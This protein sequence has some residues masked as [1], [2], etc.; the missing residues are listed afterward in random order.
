MATDWVRGCVF[1]AAD[2][3]KLEHT[4][5]NHAQLEQTYQ[6]HTAELVA[7]IGTNQIWRRLA[8]LHQARQGDQTSFDL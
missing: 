7:L 8:E 2:H 5:E 6:A 4:P 3:L 1:G